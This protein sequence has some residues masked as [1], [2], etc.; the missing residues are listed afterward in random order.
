MR[1]PTDRSMS[2]SRRGGA[3]LP[4]RLFAFA[5]LNVSPDVLRVLATQ[6]RVGTLHFYLPTPSKA[7]WGD[8]Q[9]LGA[10]LRAGEDG[11][12]ADA[13]D[14][15]LLRD[16]GAAGRDYPKACLRFCA[17]ASAAIRTGSAARWA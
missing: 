2:I 7:Y 6:S 5:V 4:S 10:R 3:G 9:T 13:D 15:P 17:T 14:N 11:F 16:W 12:G 1:S 8:L